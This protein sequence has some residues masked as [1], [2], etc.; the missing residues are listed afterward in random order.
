MS[1]K[2]SQ[3]TAELINDKL[4]ELFGR[5]WQNSLQV[6]EVFMV[7]VICVSLEERSLQL[8]LDFLIQMKTFQAIVNLV[9]N[10][11]NLL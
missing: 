5:D 3:I 8:T 4:M 10:L 1:Q 11:D 7:H 9:S 2:K 6:S